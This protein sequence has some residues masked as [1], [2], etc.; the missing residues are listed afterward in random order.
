MRHRV[1]AGDHVVMS[2]VAVWPMPVVCKRYG[3]HLRRGPALRR[4]DADRQHIP[5]PRRRANLGHLSKIGASPAHRGVAELVSQTRPECPLL[6]APCSCAVP[7][8]CSSA[9]SRAQVRGGDTVVVIGAGGIGTARSGASAVRRGS[10]PWT[11]SSSSRRPCSSAPPTPPHPPERAHWSR[12]HL[13]RVADG[14]VLS[15][16]LVGQTRRRSRA[17][18]PARAATA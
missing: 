14:V 11:P 5:P 13:R 6:S 16:S 1:R 17:D 8:G 15:P 9:A 7:T 10:S 12:P 18:S 4:R 2:F 3:I